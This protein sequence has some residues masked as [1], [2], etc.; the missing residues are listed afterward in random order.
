[1]DPSTSTCT[2][3]L[4]IEAGSVAALVWLDNIGDSCAWYA[5]HLKT[6]FV[7]FGDEGGFWFDMVARDACCACNPL[8]LTPSSEPPTCQDL[9]GWTTTDNQTCDQ[10]T[11]REQ[12]VNTES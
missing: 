4:R 1:M 6:R 12:S 2:D 9:D 8:L 7:D 11:K 3:D 10:V 5:E